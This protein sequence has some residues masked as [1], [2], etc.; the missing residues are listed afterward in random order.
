MK[1]VVYT[2]YGPPDVLRLTDVDIPVPG[3]D[4]VLVKV[5]AVSVNALAGSPLAH[6][7]DGRCVHDRGRCLIPAASRS[8]TSAMRA[9]RRSGRRLVP[10][11]Q[12]RYA[13]R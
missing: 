6:R 7:A 5:Q 11:I 8:T 1:A 13:L 9:A 10:S 2:R 4:Q 3:D 12:R